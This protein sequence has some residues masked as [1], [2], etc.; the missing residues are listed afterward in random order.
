[1]ARVLRAVFHED[2]F[3]DFDF[4]A[5]G[6]K[7]RLRERGADAL[8]QIASLELRRRNIDGD[9]HMGGP[10]H[11]LDTGP[12]QNPVAQ[13][14]DHPGF[15]GDGDETVGADQA[16]LRVAPPDQGFGG[17]NVQRPRADDG[18]IDQFELLPG[19]RRMQ[20]VAQLAPVRAP[21]F[22]VRSRRSDSRCGPPPLP[23]RGRDRPS[24]S[25]RR[26]QFRRPAPGRCRP[27][28]RW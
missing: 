5:V 4:E 11:R 28:R 16:V 20:V 17:D 26:R 19:D 12:A 10:A 18:L 6:G 15:L 7:T 25:G 13:G 1:M 3:C 9:M 24:A 2:V 21:R 8:D 27:R 23:C 14:P 22:R